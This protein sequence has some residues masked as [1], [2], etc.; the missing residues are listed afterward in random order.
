MESLDGIHRAEGDPLL[1]ETISGK[2]A[3]PE[4]K[5]LF[6]PSV[7]LLKIAAGLALL[8][9]VNVVTL[10]YYSQSTGTATA[11]NPLATEYFSYIKTITP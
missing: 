4:R 2:L 6:M 10:F 7:L 8:I 3:K 11:S 5:T 9:T 1:F